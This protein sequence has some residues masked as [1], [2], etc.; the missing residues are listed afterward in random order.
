MSALSLILQALAYDDVPATSNPTQ[1][2]IQRRPRVVNIPVDNPG[3]VPVSV[4]PGE[5]AI[6]IDGA[7]TLTID[8]TTTFSLGLSSIDPSRY[9][10]TWTGGANPGFRTDRAL[11]LNGISLTLTSLPNLTLTVV[12]S[13]GTPFAAVQVGDVAFVPGASTGDSV[14]PF[15]PLNEGSWSV[16]AVSG[17]GAGVTLARAAGS[18][19]SGV[20]ETV[21]PTTN[22]QLQ[23]FSPSG[24]QTGD[25]VDVSA[26]FAAPAQHAYEIQE[27][28]PK[29]I[30]FQ[31]ISPLGDETGVVPGA[32]G[33]VVYTAAKRFVMVESDQEVSVRLNGDTGDHLRIEP[34]VAGDRNLVGWVAHTGP[35][36]KLV[37]VNLS[38]ASANVVVASA[39]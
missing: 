22:A 34:W 27:V 36:W 38:S 30:E 15:S 26:G 9:R 23:A 11:A 31:S 25:T 35:V 5:T 3:T 4:G 28:N 37:L 19:Y 32:A 7:R 39:E 2:R 18:V 1:I 17:G 10:V 21:V 13:T 8:G 14:G 6:V 33:L 12:A 20:S 24:V 16:L 29:W